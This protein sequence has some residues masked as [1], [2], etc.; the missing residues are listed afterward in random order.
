MHALSISDWVGIANLLVASIAMYLGWLAV[1]LARQTLKET[2]DD[3]KQRKWVELYLKADDAYDA[4]DMYQTQ[5]ENA[6][7]TIQ[8]TQDFNKMMRQMRQARAMAVVFPINPT[9]EDLIA[10]TTF[11][12]ISTVA[13]AEALSKERL[14]KL[15]KA[16]SGLYEKA[17]VSRD[18][19]S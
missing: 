8:R 9:I 11:S 18:V 16:V 17:L 5:Y 3:W 2:K 14:A 15:L 19:L 6:A 10:T 7:W 4:L 13:A 12:E 1:K